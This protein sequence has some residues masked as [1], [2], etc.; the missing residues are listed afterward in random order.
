MLYTKVLH[1]NPKF[2]ASVQ[3]FPGNSITKSGRSLHPLLPYPQSWHV[4]QN[5]KSEISGQIGGPEHSQF[6]PGLGTALTFS[7]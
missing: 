4:Q 7:L 5:A 2:G 6:L 1:L 3:A